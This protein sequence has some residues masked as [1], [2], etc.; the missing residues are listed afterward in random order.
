LPDEYPTPDEVRAAVEDVHEG[1]Q[2]RDSGRVQ[3]GLEVTRKAE[4]QSA[5]R[6]VVADADVRKEATERGVSR[7]NV[8]GGAGVETGLRSAQGHRPGTRMS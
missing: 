4:Q 8:A 5:A 1:L 6:L 7:D 3:K 2:A